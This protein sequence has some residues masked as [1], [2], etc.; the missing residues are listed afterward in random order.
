MK[1]MTRLASLESLAVPRKCGSQTTQNNVPA[2]TTQE[3]FKRSF[4]IPFLDCFLQKFNSWFTTLASQ[5]VLA[6][7]ITHLHVKHFKIQTIDSIYDPFGTNLD[8]TKN[9]SEQEATVWKSHW[10][11]KKEKLG[12]IAETLR[13]PSSCLQMFPNVIKVLQLF[14]LTS[15]SGSSVERS[16]LLLQF[17]KNRMRSSTGKDRCNVLM[18]LYEQNDIELDIGNNQQFFK[19]AP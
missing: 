10:T 18:L 1:D 17:V 19:K 9:S 2:S 16:N 15:I 4:F 12:T 6:L 14:L 11:R 3:S 5:A 13:H 7:N 8:S